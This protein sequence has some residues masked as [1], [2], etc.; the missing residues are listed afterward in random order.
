MI[1][2]HDQ[3]AKIK[4]TPRRLAYVD[5][6]KESLARPLARDFPDRFS[7]EYFDTSDTHKQTRSVSKSQRTPSKNKELAYLRRS[8]RMEDRSITKGKARGERSKPRGKEGKA[9]SEHPGGAARNWFDDLNPKSVDSFKEL[10][11]KF[12]EEFSQQKRYAKD[13]TEIRGIKRRQNKGLQAFIDQFESES[14]HIKGVPSVLRISAFMHGHGHLELAK[15]LNDKIPKTVDEMFEK[16]R[17]FIRGE[18]VAGSMEMVCPSQGDKG[19]LVDGGSLSEIMYEHC[20]KSLNVNIWSRF[21]RCRAPMVGF[22]GEMYHPLGIIDLRVTIGKA[23]RNKTVLMEFA[24]VKC[25]SPY[26]VIIGRTIMRILRAT[27]GKGIRFV[28]GVKKGRFLGHM[29]TKEGVRAN[30]KKVQAIILSLTPK[31]PNQIRSLFLQ[32][33]AISKFIPKLAELQYPFARKEAE[34]SV[35]KKFFGQGEQVQE[36]PNANEGGTFNLS[37]K[38]QAKSTPTPRA[39][40]LYLGKETIKEGSGV[41]II[42]VSP[43]ER[44]HS[45]VIRLKF[46]TSDHAIDCE[47]L[48]AG[49]ADSVSKGMKDLLV[50]IDSPKLVAQTEGNHT[51]ATKQEKKYKKEI[52]DATA[53]FH[54]FRITH[55]LKILNFKAEV[56]TGLETIKLEFLNQEVSIG[57]KTRPSVEEISS[58]KKGKAASNVLV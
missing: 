56:L 9:P 5:S 19:I 4:A 30:P 8:R 3:Q 49:L 14:L 10:S 34:G 47:A 41:G 54:R 2:E 17:A 50:F 29:V 21:K 33:T 45:Y 31:S 58:S 18:V 53:P 12:F 13:P 48:L 24:I 28:E 51:P 39:W 6:D 27:P 42:L 46:N 52:M 35:V 22:S 32:L 37:K 26:N 25:R 1:K 20:F 15:K 38:L 36:T 11:Q 7:L 55:L 44:M 57:I 40:K 16:V 43:E 23:G